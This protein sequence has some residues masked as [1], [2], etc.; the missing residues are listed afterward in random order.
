MWELGRYESA[1]YIFHAFDALA[2]ESVAVVVA[3]DDDSL[4]VGDCGCDCFAD[5]LEFRCEGCGGEV[6]GEENC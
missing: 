2:G 5:L 1:D 6:A 3:G 4:G